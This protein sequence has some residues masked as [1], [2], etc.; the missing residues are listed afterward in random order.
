M[1]TVIQQPETLCFSSLLSDIVFGTSADK[2]TVTLTV[3]CGGVSRTLIDETM[4][5]DAA[6][7]ITLTELPSLVEPYARRYQQLTLGCSIDDSAT[8]TPSI[9]SIST[10]HVVYCAC[11][12]G[13]ASDA[14]AFIAG[15]FLTLLDGRRY[16]APGRGELLSAYNGT[17]DQVEHAEEVPSVT[18]KV[19]AKVLDANGRLD[20]MTFTGQVEPCNTAGIQHG[21]LLLY[22]FDASPRRMAALYGISEDRLLAYTVWMGSR[23]Q[24]YV[25]VSDEKT[26][27]PSL[28]FA[29]SFGVSEIL[30]CSGRHAKESKFDRKSARINGVLR[31]YA[32][33]ED[34]QFTAVTGWLSDAM[35][36]WADDLFRSYEVYLWTEKEGIGREVTISDSKSILT[37]VDDDLTKYEFTYTYAQRNHNVKSLPYMYDR[38]HNEPFNTTFN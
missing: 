11:E 1:A 2:G 15:H 20:V 16:T 33:R 36:L 7:H 31:H 10:V 24:D 13:V 26:P 14:A 22:Q 25:V 37:N 19:M 27:S 8:S 23:S 29:N 6:G 34:R 38:L 3:T 35:A 4:Y 30:H 9:T 18:V 28:L 5:P 21:Q 12:I 32:I 17:Y